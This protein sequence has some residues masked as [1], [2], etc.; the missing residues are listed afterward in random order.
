MHIR[1]LKYIDL[2]ETAEEMF[3]INNLNETWLQSEILAYQGKFKEA[4]TNYIKN[5]M[6][7]KAVDIYTSLK[8]FTEAKELIRKH[9]KG[10]QGDTPFLNPQI[11]I[12]Q[13]EFERDSNNWKEAADLYVQAGKHKE[14]IEIYGK[15]DNLD[16]IMEICKNLDKVKQTP[17]IELCA[18]YFKKAG[19]HMFAKQAYLRLGDIKGLM[20]LHV[21]C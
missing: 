3:N 11:L 15:Q 4:A 5:G 21:D 16:Q 20:K 8:K 7:D 2:C 13:A 14:A 1:E 12:K 6:I 9:G 19:H 18:S 10:K 17:E